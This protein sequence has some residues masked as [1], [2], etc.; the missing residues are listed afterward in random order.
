[1][2]ALKVTARARSPARLD[3]LTMGWFLSSEGS[4]SSSTALA[5]LVAKRR[6]RL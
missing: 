5:P 6:E 1:M 3:V 2:P 4:R